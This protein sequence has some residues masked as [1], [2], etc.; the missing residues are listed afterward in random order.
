MIA[1]RFGATAVFGYSLGVRFASCLILMLAACG[2][3]PGKLEPTLANV[4]HVFQVAQCVHC[5]KDGGIAEYDDKS[6]VYLTP[7]RAVPSLVDKDTYTGQ[8]QANLVP[9]QEAARA[10]IKERA[11]K[12][13]CCKRIVAGNP[14]QSWLL[15]R[16]DPDAPAFLT[17]IKADGA[18]ETSAFRM[19][20]GTVMTQE[21]RPRPPLTR[22]WHQ[23]L[24]DW[25]AAGAPE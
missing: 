16:T 6:G 10:W 1:T 15:V 13:G 3:A 11:D 21:V 17:R 8:W 7:G 18:T 14:D 25:V 2:E 12:P 4:E 22:E 23:L 5:H 24:V 9:G 20:Q 19:P